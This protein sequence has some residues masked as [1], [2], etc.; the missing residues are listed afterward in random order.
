MRYRRSDTAFGAWSAAPHICAR[1]DSETT[2]EGDRNTRPKR[3]HMGDS[4]DHH[5]G[6]PAFMNAPENDHALMAAAGVLGERH[7]RMVR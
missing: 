1:P 7:K 5:P 4:E 2:P 3:P 6:H